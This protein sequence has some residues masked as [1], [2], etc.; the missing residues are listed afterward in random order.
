[1]FRYLVKQEP[2]DLIGWLWRYVPTPVCIHAWFNARRPAVP[3]AGDL[4]CDTVASF[5][6]DGHALCTHA[7][8]VKIMA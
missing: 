5:H 4:T 1:V 3:A 6:L 8:I 2:R 7:L